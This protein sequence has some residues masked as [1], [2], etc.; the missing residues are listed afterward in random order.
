MYF[1]VNER[2]QYQTGIFAHLFRVSN[3]LQT[4]LDRELKDHGLTAKQLFLMIVID[5]FGS[6][7][8]SF[9]QAA[10][11]SGS[12]Y[13]NIKQIALKLEKSGYVKIMDDERDK[14]NKRLYL[15]QYAKD[16]WLKREDKDIKSLD[17]LFK[18]F[19]L[20]ELKT[21]ISLIYRLGD[22]ITSLEKESM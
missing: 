19:S 3:N 5:S 15:T 17:L 10:D 8:P 21:L 4:Y 9:R 14:R 7:T 16:Y 1:M 11:R 6:T 22:G 18:S 12:S 13:Q 2:M 20:E